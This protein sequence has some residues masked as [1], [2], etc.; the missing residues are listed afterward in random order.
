VIL[1][2]AGI[3]GPGRGYWLKQ[4]LSGEARIQGRGERFLN[5][6]HRDDVACAM[7]A[8]LSHGEPGRVYNATDDE[9]VTQLA[10][11][12][13]LASRLG[14]DLPPAEDATDSKRGLTSKRVS[15]RRLK[16]ELGC[17]LQYPTFRQGF[18]A[19]I[20]RLSGG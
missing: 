17:Q 1:R 4:F 12:Q 20:S 6:I 3:Y 18:A 11:F 15:N 14:R 5:M 13:W 19:E 16:S 2:V 9:P 8:A 10:L 7:I